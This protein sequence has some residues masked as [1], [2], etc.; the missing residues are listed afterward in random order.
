MSF[1]DIDNVSQYIESN[2]LDKK[3][4]VLKFKGQLWILMRYIPGQTLKSYIDT[5]K[6][7][8]TQIQLNE[9][10]QF[11]QKLLKTVEVLH[12]KGIIHRDLKPD[13][14][15]IPNHDLKVSRN[16]NRWKL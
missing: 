3:E 10:L 8:S 1:K 14:I 6:K 12:S 16:L 7:N 4:D 15:I 11:C 9:S 5:L 13:N 2:I